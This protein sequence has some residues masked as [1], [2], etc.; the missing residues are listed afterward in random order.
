MRHK[1]FPKLVLPLTLSLC[2]SFL[3][4]LGAS[5]FPR[6]AA[7]LASPVPTLT[8]ASP[9]TLSLGAFTLTLRGSRFVNGA[10][11]LWNGSPLATT[12]VS[13]SRLTA[14]GTAT[15]GGPASITVTNPGPS[16]ASS[17]VTVTVA[18]PITVAVTPQ[19]AAL[20]PGGQQQFQA[21]ITGSPNQAVTWAVNGVPG[22]GG[23]AGAISSSGLYTAPNAPVSGRVIVSAVAAA[24]GISHGTA[25][26]T[27]TAAQAIS[28]TLDPRSVNVATGGQ[29][30][31]RATVSG[32]ANQAV[33]WNVNGVVGG[34]MSDGL[35]TSAGLY[36]APSAAPASEPVTISA[37]SAADGMTQG[38]AAVTVMASQAISVTVSPGSATLPPGGQQQFQATVSG[39]TNHTVAWKVNGVAG[40]DGTNG[41]VS[42]AGLY[43]APGVPPAS[44]PVTV[45]AV[46][47]ADG[48]TQGSAAVTV[49]A[50]QTLAVT[51]SPASATLAPGTQQQ[52]QATVTGSANQAVTWKVA[53]V[54]GGDSTNGTI[55]TAG[56]Y[57]APAVAPKSGTAAISAVSAVDGVT[58]GTASV[59]FPDA[60]TITYGR[61]L[62][63]ATFG[64]TAQ[65][66][67]HVRQIGI[68]AFIDEQFAT[69]ESSWPPV[70]TASRSDA[71]DAFFS[72]PATGQD[73]LRQRV[74]FALSEIIVI[75]MNKNTNGDQ[76]VPWL[77]LLSKNAFGN[78]R[79]LLHDI[80]LDGGM[81]YYLD[82]ANSAK[83]GIDGGA[84]ENYPREVM[85]L[86]SIGLSQL[87]LDGSVKVDGQGVPIPTYTQTDVR[88]MALALTG[89]TWGNASG[90]PPADIN[91]NPFPGPML[92]VPPR[93]DTTAKTI[94]GQSLPANQ[95]PQQD[96][97]GAINIIFN[98]PNVGPFLAT[99]L[100]RAMVT[101][102][103]SPAYIT[104]VATAFNDNG[105][106]VRGDMQ[107]VIRAILLDPEARN[108]TPPN[109]FGRL[110]SPVQHIIAM[111][112]ALNIPSGQPSQFAYIFYNMG[113][114]ILDAP[115][116]FAHYSPLFHIPK[117]GLFGPEFQ[118]Y[119]PTEAV[120]RMNFSFYWIA[121]P[122]PINPALQPFVNI[123]GDSAALVT[124]VDNTLL[125][126]RMPAQ[127]RT[128]I[129]NALPP[130][131]DNNQRVMTV[132]Y[133]TLTSGD[134][135]IQH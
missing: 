54:T 135:L 10:R 3:A 25:G 89:W 86:F 32:T 53:G 71:V 40:G 87:N 30:Q 44:E 113:E 65:S 26:L 131:L 124:A 112:R 85:Q 111:M 70:S 63:Q 16:A 107:A 134:Y 11:A 33:T 29:Q 94:L 59:V 66:M 58:Q 77:Q 98:H 41:T 69:P 122:W 76:I 126:G 105:Q 37:V 5:A 23:T 61:F 127:L 21:V 114:G 13:K 12:F 60:L 9:T 4:P 109:N 128:A 81:G 125:Y 48:V 39:S 116:V 97:D 68:A 28:V 50:P 83:P 24:D 118:I 31:F 115:S 46:S 110:R 117:T 36:T 6:P 133:L 80:T 18:L 92:P 96:L 64:P 74:L 95:T 99:R 132:L 42:S 108:D 100:I 8:S 78:Y 93:H 35:I 7:P 27:V 67:A 57:T 101:S 43:T 104:R 49:T 120:N 14:T 82:L 121:N 90:T 123:A 129:L 52:F 19:S 38:T 20:A 130:A 56:L 15:Q 72:N 75:A 79:T 91:F 22:G 103:P 88:Q 73:Q 102:N 47:A 2:A 51:V 34:D 55:S 106:G 17:P 1:L 84:N 45:S 119:G 62:E